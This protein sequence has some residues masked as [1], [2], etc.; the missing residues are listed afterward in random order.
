MKF[1]KAVKKGVEAARDSMGPGR[2]ACLGRGISCPICGHDVFYHGSVL[3]NTFRMTFLE[4]AWAD[5]R[6]TT[7]ACK[8]CGY[9]LWFVKEPERTGR[10]EDL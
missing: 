6:A 3:L 1:F 9:I 10:V 4:M 7:L 2:Y 8:A 5:K